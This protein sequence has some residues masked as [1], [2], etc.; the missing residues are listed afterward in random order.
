MGV[1]DDFC[2]QE[3][4]VKDPVLLWDHPTRNGQ[5]TSK[6]SKIEKHGPVWRNLKIEE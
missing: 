2:H 6:D 3:L 4:W 1:R 5:D